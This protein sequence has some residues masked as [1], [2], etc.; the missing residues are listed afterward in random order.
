MKYDTSECP[1][2]ILCAGGR[3]QQISSPPATVCMGN[4]KEFPV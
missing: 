3:E 2:S 4:L 1:V